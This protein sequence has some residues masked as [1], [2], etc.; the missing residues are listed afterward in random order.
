MTLKDEFL[1]VVANAVDVSDRLIEQAKAN[2]DSFLVER[3]LLAKRNF[4]GVSQRLLADELPKS[5]GAGLGFSR[6][7][8][9]WGIDELFEAGSAIDR[10]HRMRWQ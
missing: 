10:F 5:K 3:L 8:S 7:L 4:E 6:E 9:E 2:Q 1:K